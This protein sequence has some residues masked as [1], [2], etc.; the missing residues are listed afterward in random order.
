MT[1]KLEFLL[2]DWGSWNAAHM[3]HANEWGTNILYAAGLMG[4]RVQD[5]SDGHKVLDVDTPIR[6][7]RVDRAV[8]RLSPIDSLVVRVFYCCPIKEDGQLY[9]TP[10]LAIL[11]H[12]SLSA[13]D[14]SLKRARKTLNRLLSDCTEL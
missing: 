6:F 8:R 13:F 12:I 14:E 1:Q 5:A 3:D 4:G 7:R 10:Q 9:T 2:R 11:T